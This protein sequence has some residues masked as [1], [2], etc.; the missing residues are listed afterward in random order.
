LEDTKLVINQ[1]ENEKQKLIGELESKRLEFDDLVRRWDTSN[2]ERAHVDKARLDTMQKMEEGMIALNYAVTK[3]TE[4][5][6]HLALSLQDLKG[7]HEE[8]AIF[9]EQAERMVEL[10]NSLEKQVLSITE[11]RNLLE[12]K[13]QHLG[14]KEAKSTESLL[15]KRINKLEKE[16]RELREMLDKEVQVRELK[17]EEMEKL[18][19]FYWNTIGETMETMKEHAEAL[20]SRSPS[21]TFSVPSDSTPYSPKKRIR[22]PYHL[23][24]GLGG[25]IH[26]IIDH[27]EKKSVQKSQQ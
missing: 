26:S 6:Q 11:E 13:L 4:D 12:E 19:H 23:R 10:K 2:K 9:K 14:E 21:P 17:L 1:L 24:Y 25:A 18:H 8:V 15:E 20:R 3:T 5:K 27:T 7:K 22:A 16:R